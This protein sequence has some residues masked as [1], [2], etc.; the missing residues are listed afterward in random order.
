MR[1]NHVGIREACLWAD[2]MALDGAYVVS[3]LARTC[4]STSTRWSRERKCAVIDTPIEDLIRSS[5]LVRRQVLELAYGA[6]KGHIGS[7]LSV[8]DLVTVTLEFVRGFGTTSPVRDRF[9]LSKGHAAMALYA[10]LAI[11]GLLSSDDLDG[12]C[13]D[14]SLIATHP[15]AAVPGIDFST[16]SL[17]QGITFAVGAALAGVKAGDDRRVFC[18][19]SDSELDEGST[20]ESALIAAHH[21]L[22]NLIVL[23]DANGQQ[24]LGRTRDVLSLEGVP[25]A[26]ASLG[27]KVTEVAGH[28][29]RAIAEVIE[30]ALDREG[31]HLLVAR[32]VAGY[33]VPFME[34]R[35]EWHYLP[36]S[37]EQF[38]IAIHSVTEGQT[39]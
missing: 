6:G 5:A 21:K 29:P 28:E 3:R 30:H 22:S 33:G 36:M 37:D 17:G 23:L 19:L 7:A 20:W 31:P 32:T 25:A 12:Y 10:N 11:R 4:V 35:V 24:A 14:G 27:W 39:L 18:I 15:M 38:T 16:G 13:G 34:G 26:W 9:V 2:L 8:A 1:H